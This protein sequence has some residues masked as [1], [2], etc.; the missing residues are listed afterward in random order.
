MRERGSRSLLRIWTASKSVFSRA[1]LAI[2]WSI[3]FSNFIVGSRKSQECTLSKQRGR[4]RSK[5]H[6]ERMQ[7]MHGVALK[8]A[9]FAGF[10]SEIWKCR[11]TL[12]RDGCLAILGVT[13]RLAQ[14]IS[15]EGAHSS[16][17]PWSTQPPPPVPQ[18]VHRNSFIS[19]FGSTARQDFHEKVNFNLTFS[20]LIIIINITSHRFLSAALHGVIWEWV[21]QLSIAKEITS[22]LK[23]FL[24]LHRLLLVPLG[25]VF[26]EVSDNP[27]LSL[28][29]PH[30]SP[31]NPSTDRISPTSKGSRSFGVL[32]VCLLW[33]ARSLCVFAWKNWLC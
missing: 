15:W 26:S 20:S 5:V 18:P 8:Y 3:S 21:E 12:P 25:I 13:A 29:N 7:T 22:G 27:H 6:I 32:F 30:L 24:V 28:R 31:K 33:L 4:F 9:P 17:S 19:A 10:V 23:L 2:F 11:Y 16:P 1:I 14:S